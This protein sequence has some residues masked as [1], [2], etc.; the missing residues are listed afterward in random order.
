MT[1]TR[2]KVSLKQSARSLVGGV[3]FEMQKTRALAVMVVNGVVAVEEMSENGICI[4]TH[5]GRLRFSGERMELSV[6]EEHC[7][8]IIG[9]I[10]N[11][12]LEYGRR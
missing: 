2:N 12:E 1:D 10:T 5:H 9:R 4:A 7:A 3:T 6:L 8:E 11:V